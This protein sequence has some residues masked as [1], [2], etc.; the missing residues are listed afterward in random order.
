MC[1]KVL[2]NGQPEHFRVRN[3]VEARGMCA[4]KIDGRLATQHAGSDRASKV[5]VSLEPGLHLIRAP[6]M[7][8]FT[9]GIE[10]SAQSRG[11]GR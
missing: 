4:L 10:P 9:R 1:R 6:G 8:V 5:V 3:A 7:E 11:Q 2:R